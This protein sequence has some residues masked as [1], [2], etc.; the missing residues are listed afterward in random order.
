MEVKL[1]MHEKVNLLNFDRQGLE[2]YFTE[3]GEK[4]FRAAQLLKWIYQFGIDDFDAMSNL[5]KSLREK[6]TEQAE[7][8]LPEIV[9][10]QLSD[11]GTIKW[12]LRLDSGNSIETVFIPE[13]DRGTLCISSQVGCALECSFCST[14]KQGFNRNLTTAEIIAQ[15]IIANR[16]LK[17]IPRN[18]RVISNIVLMG[19]GEPL[20]NFDNVVAAMN[21]MLEDNA[22]GLSKRRVTLST[23]GVIPAL[24]RLKEVSEVSLALSLHAPNDELRNE[25]VPINRKY[26]IK[27]LLAACKR[28][29][30]GETKR[31]VTI[32]YVLLDGVNDQPQH[33]RELVKLLKNFPCK[34]NLIPFNPFPNSGYA[35]SSKEAIERF[36]NIVVKGG[37]LTTTRK[38]RG[39]DIDAACGQLAGKVL[40]K[41]KRS[42]RRQAKEN[43]SSGG[44]V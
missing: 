22:Y 7:I 26:P 13:N 5:S 3:I 31:K 33:A 6:L 29:I 18:E 17:C 11:D 23:S 27:E 37:L 36:R 19:M 15:V 41:T 43:I 38:T 25:L 24:D 2:T 28:Y 42:A 9:S 35:T 16:A 21:I 1:H 20:L 30:S 34:I 12:L 14:A 40:D 8:K 44:A 10:E 32:E 39:E 4:P